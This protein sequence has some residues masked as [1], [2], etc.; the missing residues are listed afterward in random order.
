MENHAQ[1]SEDPTDLAEN[2]TISRNGVDYSPTNIQECTVAISK[3]KAEN[4]S[5]RQEV[6]KEKQRTNKYR[7]KAQMLKTVVERLEKLYIDTRVKEAVLD[8]RLQQE[9]KT[10]V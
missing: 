4:T 2:E 1:F 10:D 5:L 3:L 7:K 6:E 8:L 9:K